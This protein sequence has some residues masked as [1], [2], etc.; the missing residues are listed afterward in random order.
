[1]TKYITR[2]L[3][4]VL[5]KAAK[6]FPAVVLTGPRQAGKTTL[7]KHLFFKTHRYVSL[8][9]PDVRLAAASDP[10]GFIE[11]YQ[12]PVIF[13]EIQYAP[14]LLFY[15]KEKIDA[16]RD[17]YGQYILTG[18]QNLL[19][20]QQMTESLAGR[21][22]MLRLLPLSYIEMIDKPQDSLIW[23]I[24]KENSS[25]PKL[26]ISNFWKIVLRGSYPELSEHPEKDATLWQS[27]YIQTYLER[28]IRSLRHIGDLTQFQIFLRSV[29]IRSGQLF[30]ISDVAKELGIAVNTI[31]AWLAILEATY[32]II[33]LRPYF[34]NINKRLVKTPKVYFT[35][36]GTLCYLTGLRDIEHLASGPMAGAVVETF[37]FSE[38]FKRLSNQ[39]LDPQMY[40]WRTSSGVE[41]DLLI[42][43]QG[44]L[45]PIEIK[46]SSTPKSNMAD[47]IV[48][49]ENDLKQKMDPGYVIHLGDMVLPLT[50]NVT[51][52]PIAQL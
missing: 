46:A 15:I 27:S 19:L 5:Q 12:P 49:L 13:D 44:R 6:Q 32:Q 28:D 16:N 48:S 37:V 33:I 2:T 3:E 39:G 38:I 36:V 24:G 30:Q 40:F 4:L 35:D 20:L 43:E 11:L 17:Q 23:T 51:A 34:A 1:M 42:E 50:K 14:D 21:V 9:P 7:L 22:A 52:L 41:V 47:G 18:S 8:E 45:I 26:T 31:K 10:R 29:A 25:R